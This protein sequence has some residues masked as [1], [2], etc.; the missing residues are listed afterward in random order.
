MSSFSN[1]DPNHSVPHK[2]PLV[3]TVG[4][5]DCPGG[6][7]GWLPDI[8]ASIDMKLYVSNV[9]E[10]IVQQ[11][12]FSFMEEINIEYLTLFPK[13]K[14]SLEATFF[15]CATSFREHHNKE[16]FIINSNPTAF[17]MSEVLNF[18]PQHEIKKVF[19]V[20]E[21]TVRSLC[22]EQMVKNFVSAYKAF[23]SGLMGREETGYGSEQQDVDALIKM[24][25]AFSRGNVSTYREVIIQKSRGE[26]PTGAIDMMT[27]SELTR[28]EYSWVAIKHNT[29][30]T[31]TCFAT[32]ASNIFATSAKTKSSF[33]DRG[34][35]RQCVVEL[36][37]LTEVLKQQDNNI[38]VVVLLK[39]SKCFFQP[40]LYY[41]DYDLLVRTK[42]D[43]QLN[44][45][46]GF[47]SPT[48]FLMGHF[49]FYL[50]INKFL[51]MEVPTLLF[52]ELGD[53]IKCGWK[54]AYYASRSLYACYLMPQRQSK[55]PKKRKSD[56]CEQTVPRKKVGYS[57][58][59]F[60]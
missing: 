30:P 55:Q 39:A 20:D 36:L 12:Y 49:A 6:Y 31:A 23:C 16:T 25:L 9:S 33:G 38:K 28:G 7:V 19:P 3:A 4:S 32:K 48:E 57:P 41:P 24:N 52:T 37:A 1:I 15:S 18:L 35:D 10:D 43:I 26:L 44:H 17:T 59:T 21:C 14:E 22:Y 34:S 56:S 8:N 40:Y 46:E 2:S 29:S 27:C 60:E 13:G 51:N 53:D 42:K 58:I 54:N 47:G 11:N 45:S 5:L 50:T